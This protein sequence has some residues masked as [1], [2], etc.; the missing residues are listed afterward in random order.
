[1]LKKLAIL[2]IF[3]T[4]LTFDADAK[5]L[6]VSTT[7]SDATTYANND[8]AHPWLTVAPTLGKMHKLAI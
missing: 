2:F 4:L 5:D 8:S 3:F 1:M 7:G 6:F